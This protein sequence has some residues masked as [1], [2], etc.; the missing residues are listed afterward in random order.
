MLTLNIVAVSQ[1]EY[2]GAPQNFNTWLE[3]WDKQQAAVEAKTDTGDL[4]TLIEMDAEFRDRAETVKDAVIT[5][6]TNKHPSPQEE[7]VSTASVNVRLPKLD[8][9]KFNGDVLKFMSFWQQF[10]SC[11]DSQ[12]IP[13][14]S[15]FT[16]LLS[17]LRGK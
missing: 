15:K 14:V 12:E 2:E 9:P 10:V 1:A 17:L 8:L 13:E 5:A 4:D 6:W 11:V 3:A 7:T 16:Y